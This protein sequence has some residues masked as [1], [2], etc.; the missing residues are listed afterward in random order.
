MRRADRQVVDE[1]QIH[2]FLERAKVL[3]V[4][5][6]DEEGM[7]I[8]PMNFC[9][10]YD[11]EKLVLY[12]HSAPEGRKVSAFAADP[13]VCVEI[14]GDHDMVG[15]ETPCAYS[16]RY[17]SLIGSGTISLVEDT[18]EKLRVMQMLLFHMS[19]KRFAQFPVHG[20]NVYRID[21]TKFSVK[22]HR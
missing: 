22:M 10:E 18:A 4:G 8:V 12:V 2:D 9:F 20:V 7:Y 17:S 6:H 16:F 3:H 19:G 21:V 11:G 5:T 13:C 15:A 14:D 1:A